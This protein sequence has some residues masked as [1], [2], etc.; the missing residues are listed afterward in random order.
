MHLMHRFR[1]SWCVGGRLTLTIVALAT[2]QADHIAAEM[3]AGH[4]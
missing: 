1:R 2:R 3:S 4:L